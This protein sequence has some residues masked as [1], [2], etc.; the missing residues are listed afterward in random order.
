MGKGVERGGEREV[1][2]GFVR[3]WRK[4]EMRVSYFGLELGEPGRGWGRALVCCHG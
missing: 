4:G 1:R 3:I 2:W